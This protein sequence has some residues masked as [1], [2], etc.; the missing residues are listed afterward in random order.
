[1]LRDSSKNQHLYSAAS[2]EYHIF[3]FQVKRPKEEIFQLYSLRITGKD[4]LTKIL[5][6]SLLN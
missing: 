3:S 1:M 4:K 6:Q 5:E 2:E